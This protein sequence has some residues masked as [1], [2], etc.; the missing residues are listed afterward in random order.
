M[1]RLALVLALV[2]CT[3]S[4]SPDVAWSAGDWKTRLDNVAFLYTEVID[5]GVDESSYIRTDSLHL[6][7]DDNGTSGVFR[8]YA[9]RIFSESFRETDF[10]CDTPVEIITKDEGVVVIPAPSTPGNGT[11]GMLFPAIV[12][13][14]SHESLLYRVG[15]YDALFA[16]RRG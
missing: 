6:S 14:R 10:N 8:R 7:V 2:A 13:L 11:C 1:K 9:K 12:L 3:D 15:G 4:T 16:L 5:N